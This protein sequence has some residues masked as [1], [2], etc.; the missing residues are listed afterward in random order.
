MVMGAINIDEILATLQFWQNIHAVPLNVLYIL[1]RSPA[2]EFLFHFWI[3]PSINCQNFPVPRKN[4]CAF[5]HKSAD[6]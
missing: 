4:G 2:Q 5:S 3:F 1:I 6:L